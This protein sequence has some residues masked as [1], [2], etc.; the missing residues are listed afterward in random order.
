[1]LPWT[2]LG[3]GGWIGG[4]IISRLSADG[5][6]VKAVN[7]QR[8]A[9]WLAEDSLEGPVIYAIGLT[10]DFRNR[11]H[12]AL[13]AHVC[14]LRKVLQRRGVTR[15][16]YLSSTRVYANNEETH[17]TV[18]L[19]CYPERIEDFYNLSKLMGE[20]LV[21]QDKRPDLRV[22]RLSN[23]IGRGQP[24]TTFVG[25]L[26]E[27]ARTTGQATILQSP[28]SSKDYIS[29]DD[30]VR[31]LPKIAESASYRIYNLASGENSTHSEVARFME[32]CGFPVEVPVS[33]SE[34]AVFPRICVRRLQDEF[35]RARNPVKEGEVPF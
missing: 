4:S 11:P 24:P 30:V 27:E 35:G 21:L 5:F 16:C 18:P 12:D 22:V 31:L 14:L 33:D 23:V 13:E 20:A 19:S 26:I 7:R 28:D 34:P 1:M 6:A 25:S 29:L 15:F 32:S 3:A 2:V 8:L 17:E 10:A 9:S